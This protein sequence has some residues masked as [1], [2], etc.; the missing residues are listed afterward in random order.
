MLVARARTTSVVGAV[1]AEQCFAKIERGNASG[2]DALFF[3]L[4]DER[5]SG[6]V[7]QTDCIGIKGT[8]LIEGFKNAEPYLIGGFG[9]DD[10]VGAT[11]IG[12]IETW[13]GCV[14][15]QRWVLHNLILNTLKLSV[16]LLCRDH[17]RQ[18]QIDGCCAAGEM[19][20]WLFSMMMC[21][22]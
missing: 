11:V 6:F 2:A 10:G 19:P 8:W 9:A 17:F 21:M 22:L 4:I 12:E 5:E 1:H 18:C 20:F 3:G 14:A 13:S 7:E 16:G 15:V